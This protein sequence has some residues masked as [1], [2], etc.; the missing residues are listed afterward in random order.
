MNYDNLTKDLK[1]DD[2]YLVDYVNRM[3]MEVVLTKIIHM[4]KNY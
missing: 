3:K 2:K 4:T 1:G